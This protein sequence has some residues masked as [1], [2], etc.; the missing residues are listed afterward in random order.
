MDRI[1]AVKARVKGAFVSFK[2]EKDQKYHRTYELPPK[3]TLLG[4]I[5]SALGLKE[6]EIYHQWGWSDKSTPLMD[7]IKVAVLLNKIE[8]KVKEAW[9]TIKSKKGKIEREIEVLYLGG[10]SY[11][12]I[13]IVREQLYRPQYL[14]Y[15]S[16]SEDELLR[17][18]K[19]K[20]ENPV[21][22]LSLGRDDELVRVETEAVSLQPIKPPFLLYGI[23][24][25]FDI[26][27]I[28][29]KIALEK[30]IKPHIVHKLPHRFE[31]DKNRVRHPKD[32]GSFTFLTGY[33]A[34]IQEDINAY[35]DSM[36]DRNVVF[37]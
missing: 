34:K 12:R 29:N 14:I 11:I 30:T 24:L 18:V 8:G 21:F 20:L 23:L 3:T 32:F 17:Y 2:W 27:K 22:P 35:Y 25:P 10:W 6:E 28:K 26:A 15:V 1:N 19:E 13:P 36:E 7:R 4:F 33:K 5:G 9:K 16:C 31:I 37:L